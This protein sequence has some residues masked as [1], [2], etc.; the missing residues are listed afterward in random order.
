MIATSA[1]VLF[2]VHDE[3]ETACSRGKHSGGSPDGIASSQTCFVDMSREVGKK[4]YVFVSVHV[5]VCHSVQSTV[6]ANWH[7]SEGNNQPQAGNDIVYASVVFGPEKMEQ[8]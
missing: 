1:V 4:L 2:Q 5:C 3:K 7:P 6:Y 8:K